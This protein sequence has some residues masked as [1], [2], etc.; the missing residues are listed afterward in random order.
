MAPAVWGL[1]IEQTIEEWVDSRGARGCRGG[2]A[3][4][5]T[6]TVRIDRSQIRLRS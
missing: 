6:A 1:R 3:F 4:G 5:K 2:C